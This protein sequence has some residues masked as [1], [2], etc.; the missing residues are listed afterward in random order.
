MSAITRATSRIRRLPVNCGSILS[1]TPILRRQTIL[2]S[3]SGLPNA[4][5]LVTPSRPFE[6]KRW[7]SAAAQAVEAEGEVQEE[8]WPERILPTVS[9]KDA[10]RLKRQRNVGMYVYIDLRT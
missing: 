1:R 8:V 10:Q 9:D 4:R 3:S 6:Q 5:S 2:P 7:S